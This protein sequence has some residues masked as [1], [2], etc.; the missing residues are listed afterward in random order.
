MCVCVCT[1]V[2][3]Q[4][5]LFAGFMITRSNIHDWLREFYVS[6]LCSPALL[7]LRFTVCMCV[8]CAVGTL[9]HEPM[10]PLA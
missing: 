4:F 8:A 9:Q 5:T 10:P 2:C 6:A 1:R 7:S 3:L